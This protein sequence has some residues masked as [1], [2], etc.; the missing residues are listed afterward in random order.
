MNHTTTGPLFSLSRVSG[1]EPSSLSQLSNRRCSLV[2]LEPMVVI[3]S[4]G[5]LGGGCFG[6]GLGRLLMVMF[7]FV[8][9]FGFDGSKGLGL[10]F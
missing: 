4:G 6:V 10:G 3:S 9:G 7:V 2:H 8:A 1:F 5:G